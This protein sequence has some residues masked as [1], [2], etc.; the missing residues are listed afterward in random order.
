MGTLVEGVEAAGQPCTLAVLLPA[1]GIVLASGRHSWAAIAGFLL[2]T[3]VVAWSRATGWLSLDADGIWAVLAG[4]AL[5]GAVAA[6]VTARSRLATTAFSASAV[7][8]AVIGWLWRPCVGEHLGA[9]L[10]D[11]PDARIRTVV[12]MVVYVTGTC[13]VAVMVAALPVAVP[14]LVRLR[15]H[16]VVRSTGT[17]VVGVIAGLIVIGVY[18]DLVDELLRRSTA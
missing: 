12:L 17:V 3:A 18:D 7:G 6:V 16:R 14:G 13:L 11:A 9:I 1:L 2:G 5:G 10:T 15:D 8:G 4:C